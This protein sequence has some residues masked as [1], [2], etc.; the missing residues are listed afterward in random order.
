MCMCNNNIQYVLYLQGGYE[1]LANTLMMKKISPDLCICLLNFGT[2][3][4]LPVRL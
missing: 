2:L 3:M 1:N 4:Y